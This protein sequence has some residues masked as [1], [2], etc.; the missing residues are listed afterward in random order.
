MTQR[1]DI[2]RHRGL[3]EVVYRTILLTA[4]GTAVGQ[5]G[6][7]GSIQGTV[8]DPS[9][10]VVPQ[11][12]VTAVN[13]ATGVVMARQ[14]TTAGL[15]VISPLSQGEYNVRVSA[16]GFQTLTQEHVI[17]E[18]LATVALD[19][20]LK[21]GPAAEQITVDATPPML[22]TEDA[23]LGG[24]MQN[25]VYEA[26]PLAMN[27]VPRDPT[28]FV[29]LIAGVSNLNTQVAGP[30]TA[31]FNGAPVGANELYVEGLPLTFPSQQADTRNLALRISAEALDQFQ[32]ETNGE[33]AMLPGKRI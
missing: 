28:Q 25:N 14:T 32:A 26:L 21:V 7:G 8:T 11:A 23:T 22:H 16:S 4:T 19:L 6:G 18:A 10:A 17:V 29:G 2:R 30:S 1:N 13:A 31:S 20:Q 9:G 33:K 27:G 5:I 24:S 3:G 12:A 15:Y